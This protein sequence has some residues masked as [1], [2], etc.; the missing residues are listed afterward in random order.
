MISSHRT[1]WILCVLLGCFQWAASQE[2]ILDEQ[3]KP[4]E[5]ELF[6]SLPDQWLILK[7][8]EIVTFVPNPVLSGMS[9]SSTWYALNGEVLSV[10]R[11]GVVYQAPDGHDETFDVLIWHNPSSGQW[12]TIGITLICEAETVKLALESLDGQAVYRIPTS[13]NAGVQLF[14]LHGQGSGFVICSSGRPVNPP[15]PDLR[16]SG[17]TRTSRS[18]FFRRCG[19]WQNCRT[20]TVDVTIATRVWNA[21]RIRLSIG[22]TVHIRK[23]SCVETKMT[24]QD[25]YQCVNGQLQYVG[26][27]VW[28]RTKDFQEVDP[29]WGDLFC[30]IGPPIVRGGCIPSGNCLCP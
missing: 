22:I 29:S 5:I 14:A 24:L 21:Y 10:S 27:R 23:R 9:E 6:A 2:E 25:C 11:E 12:A 18:K 26:T 30:P 13:S 1:I 28:W 4:I 7:P 16:C 8:S 20:I 3:A 17:D 19:P 15:P